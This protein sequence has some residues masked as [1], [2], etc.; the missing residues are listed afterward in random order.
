MSNGHATPKKYPEEYFVNASPPN[1][2]PII[3]M[4]KDDTLC[5]VRNALCALKELAD[6]PDFAMTK[7][8]GSGYHLLMTCLVDAVCFDIYSR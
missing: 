6:T 1:H 8:A 5:N 3:G 4:L 2:N 7:N